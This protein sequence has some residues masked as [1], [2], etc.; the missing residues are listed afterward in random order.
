M[1][2]PDRN[3]ADRKSKDREATEGD[4]AGRRTR[5][6]ERLT[7]AQSSRQPARKGEADR[8]GYAQALRL[9][10][11]FVSAILVG[12]AIGWAIDRFFA[13]APWAMITFLLLGFGAG[14]VNVLRAAGQLSDPHQSAGM[15]SEA[16]RDGGDDRK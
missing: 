15:G 2:G 1:S 13:T 8:T 12:A 3:E 9:S 10:T 16:D 4:L 5:L 6:G 11:E 14:I 7:R